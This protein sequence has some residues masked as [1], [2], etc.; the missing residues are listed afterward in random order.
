MGFDLP[1][2]PWWILGDVFMGRYYSEFDLENRRIG[3]ADS[4][5]DP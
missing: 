3:F 5:A 2:G 1:M 4:I